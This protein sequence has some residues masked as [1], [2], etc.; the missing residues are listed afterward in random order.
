MKPPKQ[1]EKSQAQP[2]KDDT[3]SKEEDKETPGPLEDRNKAIEALEQDPAERSKQ[4]LESS[5]PDH[6]TEQKPPKET[7]AQGLATVMAMPAPAAENTE[8]Q[9]TP[10]LAT[11]PYV[12]NFDT[13][14]LVKDLEKGGFQT[15]QSEAIMK[16]VRGLLTVNLD[17][18]KDG[19]V[20]KS[21]VE[22]VC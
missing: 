9:K 5:Q 11:P 18:A 21:D 19:L 16:G 2:S 1:Q 8:E 3:Q 20:S 17:M 12:H 22:N 13:Y 7:P 4:F 10:Y 15:G 14:T 6:P